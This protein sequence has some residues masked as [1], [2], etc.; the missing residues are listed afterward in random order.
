M[1]HPAYFSRTIFS[2][3]GTETFQPTVPVL[4][5]TAPDDE[6]VPVDIAAAIAHAQVVLI[7]VSMREHVADRAQLILRIV[8][9]IPNKAEVVFI[10]CENTLHDAHKELIARLPA[11]V[12]S[13]RAIVDR[14][15]TWQGPPSP[16]GPRHVVYHEVGEWIIEDPGDN[17]LLRRLLEDAPEVRFVKARDL[18]KYEARKAWFVNGMHLDLAIRG[19]AVNQPDLRL[20]ADDPELLGM[21][22]ATIGA[23]QV[24]IERRHGI[25]VPADWALDRLR[26]VSQLPDSCDRVLGSLTRTDPSAFLKGFEK[27]IGQPA[28]VAAGLNSIPPSLES[29]AYDLAE[30]LQDGEQY[31][32]W[33]T[34]DPHDLSEDRDANAVQAFR[35]ATTGWMPADFVDR[36]ARRLERS[37]RSQRRRLLKAKTTSFGARR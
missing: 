11:R 30:I 25:H 20:V 16:Q 22:Q 35:E 13:L 5:F 1:E 28:R 18:P 23:M 2:R 34:L 27:R 12:R 36:E 4:S 33:R 17:S 26:V 6:T 3:I 10:A 15:C 32:D 29:L 9:Q 8:D 21:L 37:L 31:S 7:T 19:R 14:V 24:A